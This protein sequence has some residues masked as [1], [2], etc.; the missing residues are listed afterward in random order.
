MQIEERW[1]VP[2]VSAWT[3]KSV[4]IDVGANDGEW[5][6]LLASM[7][8][9]V[10][11]IEPDPRAYE[12]IA[13]AENVELI[14]AAAAGRSGTG[15]LHLRP[16]P[17]Q[18]SLLE[19]HPIG[20]PSGS[21]APSVGTVEVQ[22]ISLEDRFP[23]GAD[24]VKIDVE[25]AEADVLSGCVTPEVWKRT[26]FIVECHANGDAVAAELH[27]LGKKCI[28]VPHPYVHPSVGHFWIVTE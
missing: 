27:R 19:D 6:A 15:T 20:G 2:F 24:L 9:Q 11:A 8:G 5:T 10:Y 28:G 17:D 26:R 18:N 14:H 22:T 23:D 13:L 3:G 12:K 25:G 16:S 7:F 21:S 4:A 1:L